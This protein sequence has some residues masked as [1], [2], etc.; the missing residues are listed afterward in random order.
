ME[1]TLRTVSLLF[2]NRR[3]RNLTICCLLTIILASHALL[4]P[5]SPVR[6]GNAATVA[7]GGGGKQEREQEVAKITAPLLTVPPRKNNERK[8]NVSNQKKEEF[9]DI[10]RKSVKKSVASHSA[11]RQE[12][13]KEGDEEIDVAGRKAKQVGTN[14][15]GNDAK[16]GKSGENSLGDM[17]K[18]GL[19]TFTALQTMSKMM[20]GQE[21]KSPLISGL[22]DY[23]GRPQEPEDK[24]RAGRGKAGFNLDPLVDSVANMLGGQGAT[25]GIKRFAKPLLNSLLKG[26]K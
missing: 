18:T 26:N 23:L 1:E 10:L 9:K 22:M 7:A 13:K 24:S 20:G 21:S 17:V 6:A 5:L 16:K 12:R 4:R 19:D 3:A 11:R 8:V 15:R 2:Q 14:K 25:G